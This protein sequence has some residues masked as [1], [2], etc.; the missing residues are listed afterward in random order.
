[1]RYKPPGY[2]V[3]RPISPR[4]MISIVKLTGVLLMIFY[5]KKS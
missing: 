1:M 5:S 2:S 3:P 4:A